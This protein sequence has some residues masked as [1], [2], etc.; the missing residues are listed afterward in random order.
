[1]AALRFLALRLLSSVLQTV[2]SCYAVISAC[3]TGQQ[4]QHA[5]GTL[6]MMLQTAVLPKVISYSAVINARE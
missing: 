5:L 2:C 1:M 6:T 3:G 4:W